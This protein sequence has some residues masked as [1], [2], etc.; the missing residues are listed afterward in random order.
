MWKYNLLRD[1]LLRAIKN[2]WHRYNPE[3]NVET[4]I[5]KIFNWI[6]KSND[7]YLEIWRNVGKFKRLYSREIDDLK[8]YWASDSIKELDIKYTLFLKEFLWFKEYSSDPLDWNNFTEPLVDISRILDDIREFLWSQIT[9]ERSKQNEEE[10]TRN[11]LTEEYHKVIRSTY[12]LKSGIEDI[13]GLNINNSKNLLNTPFLLLKWAAWVWKTHI[14]CDLVKKATSSPENYSVSFISFWEKCAT[15]NILYDVLLQ[16]IPKEYSFIKWWLKNSYV[17]YLVCRIFLRI[18]NKDWKNNKRRS[19]IIIDAIN[20]NASQ[21]PNYWKNN[22]DVFLELLSRY[23]HIGLILSIRSG[24]ENFVLREE[25]IA[26]F[27]V[28]EHYWFRSYENQ[29]I[30]KFFKEFHIPLPKVPLFITEF[31]NPLFLMIFCKAYEKRVTLG[32]EPI[33]WHEWATHIFEKF[34]DKIGKD[35]CKKFHLSTDNDRDIWNQIVKEIA[36]QMVQGTTETISISSLR[37][38][39]KNA[40]PNLKDID[41]FINALEQDMILTK[42]PINE[43]TFEIRFPF[44]RF[45]DH[46][47]GRYIFYEMEA[48][49]GKWC[50]ITI[51]Q[52]K[53]FFSPEKDLGRYIKNDWNLWIIEA[54]S[55]QCPERTTFEFIELAPYILNMNWWF[56]WGSKALLDSIIWR[57]ID[58]FPRVTDLKKLINSIIVSNSDYSQT[59]ETFLWVVAIPNHPFNANFLHSHLIKKSMLERDAFWSSEYLWSIWDESMVYKLIDWGLLYV[60]DKSISDEVIELISIVFAWLFSTSN[61]YVRDNA[62]IALVKILH[63]RIHILLNILKKFEDI[64]DPYILERIYGVAYWCSLHIHQKNPE[65]LI[66]AKHVYQKLFA[67]WKPPLHALIRD[68][69]RWIIE[70]TK[71]L[72]PSLKITTK[73]ITPPFLSDWN[74][75]GILTKEELEERY[76]SELDYN[77]KSSNSLAW[78]RSIWYSLME[79]GDFSRYIIGTNSNNTD[80]SWWKIW[81]IKMS[82]ESLL[83]NFKK[84]LSKN[85]KILY[86]KMTNYF[87]WISTKN[88]I[89][90]IQEKDFAIDI[91]IPEE[92][93]P[94]EDKK[95]KEKERIDE[96]KKQKAFLDSLNLEQRELFISEI[97]PYLSRWHINEPKEYFNL[98]LAQSWIFTR[99]IEMGYSNELFWEFDYGINHYR[100]YSRDSKLVER[101]WKKFQWIAYH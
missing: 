2:A 65:L 6:T 28:H 15:W 50:K 35:I 78:I 29:A 67:S 5:W 75:N 63:T 74:E 25:Q 84:S 66:L 58:A 85:Q 11:K 90:Y 55:I 4:N 12:D 62:T 1:S 3:L 36:K 53:D 17:R 13:L 94:E 47:I 96:E 23:K 101:I 80:W 69:W 60:D 72:H 64:D 93:P 32:K 43:S 24:F 59:I 33:A 21:Y 19:L 61:R 46:L 48:I 92:L 100:W 68:Y 97:Q 7:L 44:Q 89:K 70:R 18:L 31:Q 39:V 14:L 40:Y 16:I 83:R 42:I 98:K 52:W 87:Y 79:F 38:I 30:I 57:K 82:R 99:I 73:S 8:K 49:Y 34:V 77:N 27:T 86:E 26:R 54:L 41:G 81:E 71:R 91:K 20:E 56:Y 95:L 51:E 10:N 9:I 22:L 37:D 76:K 88:L 45:S